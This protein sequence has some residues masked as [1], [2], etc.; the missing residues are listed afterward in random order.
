MEFDESLFSKLRKSHPGLIVRA[1]FDD[2]DGR[3]LVVRMA[4]YLDA[5]NSATFTEALEKVMSTYGDLRLIV[6]DLEKLAYISSTGI[7]AFANVLISAKEK[8]ILLSLVKLGDNVRSVFDVLGI[9]GFFSIAQ[10]LE[11]ALRVTPTPRYDLDED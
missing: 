9:S 11:E 2:D 6:F 5:N 8:G 7:G 3:R 4:G 1:H 10:S